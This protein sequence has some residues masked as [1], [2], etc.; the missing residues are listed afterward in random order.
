MILTTVLLCEIAKIFF[1]NVA[2]R[3]PFQLRFITDAFENTSAG[4]PS[5]ASQVRDIGFQLHYVM[6]C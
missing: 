3:T 1:L 6:S 2:M 4:A 5:E